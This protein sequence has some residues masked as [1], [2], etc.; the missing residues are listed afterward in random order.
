MKPYSLMTIA[1]LC[2]AA[3][4]LN[5]KAPRKNAVPQDLFP[6]GTPVPEWFHDTT[7]VDIESLG[8]KYCLTD[9]HIMPDGANIK[10]PKK[11]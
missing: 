8:R 4:S 11:L 1:L 6:D 9:Y 10:L 5:A 7:P 2:A 3:F